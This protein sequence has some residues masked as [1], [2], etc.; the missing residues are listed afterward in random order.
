MVLPDSHGVSRVPRYLGSNDKVA[1]VS[2]TG[3]SPSL[4]GL[5]RPFLYQ[6]RFLTLRL[7]CSPASVC[8]A[9]PFLHPLH[10]L[11]QSRFRLFRF[12]SPLLTESLLF[13]LPRVTEMFQFSR[14]PHM[15]L[16]IQCT[17]PVHHDWWVPP[18]GHPRI[19]AR[20]QLPVAFRCSPRPSSAPSA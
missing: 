19:K 10:G 15:H 13:S 8:P 14:L 2:S 9:T 5:P 1:F 12:R 6:L 7:V 11:S 17:V 16:C 20:L 4:A 18:F 3:L